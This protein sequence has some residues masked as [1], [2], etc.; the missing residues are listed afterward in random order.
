LRNSRERRAPC[1][2]AGDLERHRERQ[3]PGTAGDTQP[4]D[5]P[6]T[7]SGERLAATVEGIA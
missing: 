4:A 1:A 2:L 3:V 5:T 7:A 6:R